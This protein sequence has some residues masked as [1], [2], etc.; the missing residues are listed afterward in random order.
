MKKTILFLYVLVITSINSCTKTDEEIIPGNQPPP[1]GTISNVIIENYVN[2]VYISVLGR[3]ATDAEFN[4]G[5]SLLKQSNLSMQSREQFLSGVFS[6]AGYKT[7]LYEKAKA[8]LLNNL[9]TN[10]ITLYISIFSTYLADTAYAASWDLFQAE[11]DK[12]VE[13]QQVPA[14]LASGAINEKGMFERCCNNYFY[15]QINMGSSNYVVSLF[16]HFLDRYPT[17]NELQ[18]GIQMV[19]GTSGTLF[20]QSGLSKS[21]LIDIF[22]S[23]GDYYEGQVRIFYQRYLFRAPTSVEMGTATQLY[24]STGDYEKMQMDILATNEYIGI[25]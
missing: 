8:E 4:S 6:N 15:D 10:E 13:L 14:D 23:S 21:D 18:Q 3:K 1:D 7:N 16:Q 5:I 17:N 11:L 22:F 19:D 24:I 20:L 25:E 12:L 9:D 2:R